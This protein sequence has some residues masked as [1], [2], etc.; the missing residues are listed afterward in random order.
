MRLINTNLS[1]NQSLFAN[2]VSQ[3]N[4]KSKKKKCGRLPEQAIAQQSWPP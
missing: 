4:N 2:A 1:I 3:V